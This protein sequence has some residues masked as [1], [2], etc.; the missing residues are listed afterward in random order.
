[1]KGFRSNPVVGLADAV[2]ATIP[3]RAIVCGLHKETINNVVTYRPGDEVEAELVKQIGT[4][5]SDHWLVRFDGESV[6][7]S[8][9]VVRIL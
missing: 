4:R 9:R 6:T 5:T 1:M 3:R 8:R 7:R 2:R